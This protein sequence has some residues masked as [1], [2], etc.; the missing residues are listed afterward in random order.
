MT[1]G[2]QSTSNSKQ[3][4]QA[5]QQR[6]TT[7]EA[8][9]NILPCIARCCRYACWSAETTAD[10]SQQPS[11]PR[12]MFPRETNPITYLPKSV[13]GSSR[14]THTHTPQT[15]RRCKPTHP[16]TGRAF[17]PCRRSEQWHRGEAEPSLGASG[18]ELP[19]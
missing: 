1:E 9:L 15:S 5:R 7:T 10:A 2:T 3:Q 8:A 16:R 11:P 19:S 13:V 4:Q 17:G 18:A 12:P 14:P 6:S